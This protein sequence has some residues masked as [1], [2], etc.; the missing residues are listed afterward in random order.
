MK[1]QGS[2]V[3]EAEAT[4]ITHEEFVTLVTQITA[5]IQQRALVYFPDGALTAKGYYAPPPQE[6]IPPSRDAAGAST[7]VAAV[8]AAVTDQGAQT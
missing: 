4:R 2:I 5:H 7:G 8:T 1:R 6:L 3:F